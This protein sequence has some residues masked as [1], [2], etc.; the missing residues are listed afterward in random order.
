[1]G[2]SQRI[3]G[4]AAQVVAG[5]LRV[6]WSKYEESTVV[7]IAKVEDMASLIPLKLGEGWLF[8]NRIDVETWDSL[9]Y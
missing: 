8:N 7:P 1:M 9:Y 2:L 5:M 3:Y 6:R 4:N